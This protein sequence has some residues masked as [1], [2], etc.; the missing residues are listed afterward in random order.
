MTYVSTVVISCFWISPRQKRIREHF[1][2]IL[3]NVVDEIEWPLVLNF[4]QV[5]NNLFW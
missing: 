2:E 5:Y 3:F 1:A 4:L